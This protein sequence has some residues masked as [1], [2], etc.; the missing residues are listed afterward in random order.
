MYHNKYLNISSGKRSDPGSLFKDSIYNF[1]GL[2]YI[3]KR[4]IE[5]TEKIYL[6]TLKNAWVALFPTTKGVFRILLNIKDRAFCK[7]N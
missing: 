7:H 2:K 5:M 4:H 1:P 6:E 3:K